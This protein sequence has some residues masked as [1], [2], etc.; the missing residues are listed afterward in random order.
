[1]A[2]DS[3]WGQIQPQVRETLA[4]FGV[5]FQDRGSAR[6]RKCECGVGD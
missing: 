4:R 3:K 1:M 5:K 6:R 2:I